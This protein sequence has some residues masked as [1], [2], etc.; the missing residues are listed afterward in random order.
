VYV[1]DSVIV[2][3]GTAIPDRTR[4]SVVPDWIVNWGFWESVRPSPS[5]SCNNCVRE[6]SSL[7]HRDDTNC[8]VGS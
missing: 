7:V 4:N 3:T 5:E 6:L 8:P 1:A 2:V